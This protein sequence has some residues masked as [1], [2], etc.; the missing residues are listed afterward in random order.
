MNARLESAVGII[1]EAMGLALRFFE[2][3][4]A[5]AT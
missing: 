4:D 1:E 5:I 2:A 3:R